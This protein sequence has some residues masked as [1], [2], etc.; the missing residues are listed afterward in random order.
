[1]CVSP[2]RFS[3]L[4]SCRS[5]CTL[6]TSLAKRTLLTGFWGLWLFIRFL[7]HF[8]DLAVLG[9]VVFLVL[10]EIHS[11]DTAGEDLRLSGQRL[12]DRLLAVDP[13]RAVVLFVH[14]GLNGTIAGAVQLKTLRSGVAE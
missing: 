6:Q 9:I 10:F 1:M 11:K 7:D 2:N 14:D 3:I 13:H 8:E 12:R 4:N 5:K